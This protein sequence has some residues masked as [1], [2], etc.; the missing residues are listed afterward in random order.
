MLTKGGSGL[1]RLISPS[2]WYG[3]SEEVRRKGSMQKE[4]MM[5]DAT[6]EQ[7]LDRVERENRLL[8]RIGAVAVAFIAALILMGQAT[9]SRVAKVVEAEHF[10]LRDAR[11]TARAVLNVS[12][13]SVN[14][15]L[16]DHEGKHRAVLYVLDDGTAGLALRDKDLTRRNVLYVLPDGS[17]GLRL[18]GKDGQKRTDLIVLPDGSHGLILATQNGRTGA[19]LKVGTNGF[20]DLSLLD[21]KGSRIGLFMVAD[22]QPAFGLVDE[23]KRIRAALGMEADGRVRL[24]LSDKGATERAE[25][26]VLPNERPRLS[27]IGHTG[28]LVWHGP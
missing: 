13:N 4:G 1:R 20:P 10:V 28:R 6:I 24:V 5:T 2:S 11:G 19:E 25:I 18:A 12:G 27:L 21:K 9:P 16:A 26:V 14:L 8:K 23:T 7:R 3:A 17:S 22:G 15:A